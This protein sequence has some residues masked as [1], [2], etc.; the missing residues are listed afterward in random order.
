MERCD[1]CDREAVS[2]INWPVAHVKIASVCR[3]CAAEKTWEER[4]LVASGQLE[5]HWVDRAEGSTP[6]ESLLHKRRNEI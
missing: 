4:E 6:E 2:V 5:V 1:I 3:D